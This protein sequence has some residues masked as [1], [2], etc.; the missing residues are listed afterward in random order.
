M[1]IQS[2]RAR[3][4]PMKTSSPFLNEVIAAIRV[5]H[6]SI[7]TEQCYVG[8]IRRFIVFHGKRHPSEMGAAEVGDFL[9]HLA[10]SGNVAASTRNQALKPWSLCIKPFSTNRW[11]IYRGLSAQRSL[12]ACQWCC[13]ARRS[14]LCYTILRVFTGL[15]P[16]CCMAPDCD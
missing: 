11:E 14:P 15:P 9:T 1:F 6:Y 13:P 12:D 16:A 2:F 5:R 3:D 4:A 8:W 7:R 10:V